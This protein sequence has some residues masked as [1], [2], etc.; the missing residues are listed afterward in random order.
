LPLLFYSFLSYKMRKVTTRLLAYERQYGIT[1][2]IVDPV[3]AKEPKEKKEPK[4][5]RTKKTK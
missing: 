2:Q 3:V 1:P 5:K 4:T